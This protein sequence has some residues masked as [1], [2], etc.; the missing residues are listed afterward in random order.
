[1]KRALQK[2]ARNDLRNDCKQERESRKRSKKYNKYLLQI[3]LFVIYWRKI[4][5][6]CNYLYVT[7]VDNSRSLSF[8]IS[9]A[10]A[11]GRACIIH[12]RPKKKE[13]P[14]G[15][16]FI[17]K[18]F[19][20]CK[21]TPTRPR[22]AGPP[23]KK[24]P[25]GRR[26][27]IVS[28]GPLCSPDGFPLVPDVKRE[29]ATRRARRRGD[30][31]LISI[32]RSFAFGPSRSIWTY[33][34]AHT[35]TRSRIDCSDEARGGKRRGLDENGK[36]RG[37]ETRRKTSS[38]HV[39]AT[40][41]RNYRAIYWIRGK[42]ADICDRGNSSNSNERCGCWLV[43]G[44]NGLGNYLQNSRIAS[45]TLGENA[46]TAANSA[47]YPRSVIIAAANCV[48]APGERCFRA[49]N[50]QESDSNPRTR[51]QFLVDLVFPH[52]YILSRYSVRLC[53]FFFLFP[54]ENVMSEME[55]AE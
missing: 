51:T 21:V 24:P 43:R 40:A 54:D 38:K 36:K 46:N 11:D 32:F 31:S 27:G 4:I 10:R 53:A 37:K 33:A 12:N 47:A 20:A 22:R 30:Y 23:G 25:P 5:V 44:E 6:L 9:I 3:C 8:K 45:G 52:G 1:M 35:R 49:S 13:I 34:H 26:Y 29:K 41:S 39:D 48:G 42:G 17:K 15:W 19:V 50:W 28:R 16:G 18:A 55:I 14:I 2:H 7:I